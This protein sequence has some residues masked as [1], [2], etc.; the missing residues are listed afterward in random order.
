MS[1]YNNTN[2][3]T[4]DTMAIDAFGRWRVSSPYTVFDSK[5]IFD[6]QPLFWD[7]QEVS[8]GSTSSTYSQPYARSRMLVAAN[9]AGNRTRQTFMRFN[10]QPGKSQLVLMTFRLSGIP[11]GITASVG[12]FDD[13]NGIFFTV[14][15]GV[16]KMV[17]RT[18]V[19]GSPADTAVA[20]S[21]WNKDKLDG[22]GASGITLDFT[23][24]Q[25]WFADYEWLGVGRCRVGFCIDG[26]FVVAHEFLHANSV[27]SVYMSTPNLPLRL[28]II[29]DGT[30]AET[31]LDHIC[32]SVM[33][34]GGFERTGKLVRVST[35]GTP[36]TATTAG[37]TYAVMG[38]R[39]KSTHLG[40][41]ID[42]VKTAIQIQ[43]ASES[44]EWTLRLN[45]TVAAAFVYADVTNS[46]IQAIAGTTSN[47]VTG[48]TILQGGFTTSDSGG[49]GKG[50]TEQ[51]I[52]NAIRLGSNIAGTP[53][54]MVLCWMPNAS[55]ASHAIEGSITIRELS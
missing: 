25:I 37:T 39:L 13:D 8:G 17:I 14:I 42:I 24:A 18:S 54:T 34:E 4:Q 35:A 53:D 49:A 21:A 9:T 10:Y 11:S 5:Q 41:V 38:I 32:A 16:A 31:T 50:G 22:T 51:F 23:K 12:M 28:S 47:T 33:S 52:E 29:N 7:D 19:T 36:M 2:I 55:T 6:N 44:G 45:P 1:R 30:A 27:E 26:L 48:G 15:D 20:Q 3:T 46:A 40:A 43:S